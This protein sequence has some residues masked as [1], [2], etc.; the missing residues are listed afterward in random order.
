M[1]LLSNKL[2]NAPLLSL[3][4]G[5]Q[6]AQTY[7]YIISPNN[8]KIEGFYCHDRS[9]KQEL[10]LLYQDIRN[11]IDHGIIINDHDVLSTPDILVRLQDT[12]KLKFSLVGKP[13]ITVG[14]HKVG[15]VKDFAFDSETF[16]VQK[17][18]VGQSVMK[19]FNLGQLSVDRSQIV[20]VTDS[21]I[22]IQELL[23]P[24]KGIAAPARVSSSLSSTS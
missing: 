17:L 16:Y 13:V 6:I 12:L 21:K 10:I 22:I 23:K 18:Y 1:L 24:S 20:E 14:K 19:N 2:L 15:K 8:L 7:A 9:S 3:R 5:G 4:T 11:I